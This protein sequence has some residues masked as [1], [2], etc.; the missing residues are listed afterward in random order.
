MRYF[1]ALWHD[2]QNGAM[3][4]NGTFNNQ[5]KVDDTKINNWRR[6]DNSID[7][8]KQK[9]KGQTWSTTLHRKLTIGLKSV[10]KSNRKILG[11]DAKLILITHIYMTDH[12]DGLEP[13]FQ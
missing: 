7:K 8:R 13:K 10:S 12:F 11:T 3:M 5:E 6:T 9:A 2:W 1:V 4:F